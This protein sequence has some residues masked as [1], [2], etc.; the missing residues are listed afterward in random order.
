[1]DGGLGKTTACQH[2]PGTQGPPFKIGRMNQSYQCVVWLLLD[3][4]CN[5]HATWFSA[6]S[7]LKNEALSLGVRFSVA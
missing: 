2:S 1:V 6:T 7:A 4:H 3:A 5:L